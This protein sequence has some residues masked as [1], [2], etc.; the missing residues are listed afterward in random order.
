MNVISGLALNNQFADVAPEYPTFSALVTESNRR[1]LVG[2]A[3][4]ALAGG[5]RTKDAVV[6]LDG[7]E[8]LD[9]DRI[10]PTRSRYAQEVLSRL[11]AKGHG[12]VLNRAELVSGDTDVEHFAPV[13]FR[14]EPDLLVT[15]LGGLVYA[16]DVVLAITGD[17]IDSG[18]LTLLAERSLD[19]LKQFKHV[20]APKEINVAV[21]RSLFEMLD[22]PP[23]LAQQATQGSDEPV[24]RLQEEVSKLTRRVLSATTDMQ[25]RL[26]FWGQ[27]LLRD[28]EI[29]DWRTKLDALKS[30][31]ESLAPYNTVGKLKNL[32]IGSDDIAAQ[33]KNLEVLGAVERMLELVGELGS[34]ASYLSQAEMVLSP[35][36]DWVKKAQDTRK[37]VLEKL[38]ADRTAQHAAEYR[39]TL[40]QLKKDYIA[41]YTA[42]HSKARLGVAED[43]TKAALQKDPRLVSMRALAGISLLPTSQLTSFEE[44]LDKLKSCASLVDSELTASP[45]CPHCNFRPA[46][47]QGDMLPAANVLKQLDDELDR[48]LEN[49]VQT[50][51]ENL[52]DP[53][54]QSNFELLKDSSRKIVTGF[55]E[56]GTLPDMV[57]PEFI[58]AV[59]EALSGLEKITVTSEDIKQALLQGGSPAT[60][61]DLRKRFEALLNDRCKGKDTTKLRFVVE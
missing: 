12:Q 35:D 58:A 30:F 53:I 24:K 29:A 48:L 7:L 15:V 34:T 21:L 59:Q 22:L 28:E 47:E 4:R 5:N 25:G 27:P 33:K 36:H 17:K 50:L 6:I 49:W 42:Q 31:S 41:A 11:K 26:S 13:K 10:D 43:K 32:R 8:M 39:K 3:L 2:N 9:G 61:E 37:Q 55:A 56:S 60:P 54:I 40:G 52:E 18:K 45:V 57:T 16:G 38:A 44:K 46:N 1:Q 23:G 19:E 51:V 14:L 20:E